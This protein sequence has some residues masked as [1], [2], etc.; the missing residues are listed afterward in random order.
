LHLRGQLLN[1]LLRPFQHIAASA[2]QADASFIFGDRL[3][4]ADLP[5][6]NAFDDLLKLGDRLLERERWGGVW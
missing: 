3:F 6:L 5:R 2:D 4:D 1:A